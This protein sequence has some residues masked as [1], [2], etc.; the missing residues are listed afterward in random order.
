MT[1]GTIADAV[2][3]SSTTVSNAYNR[4]D[5]LSP[6]LRERILRTAEEFGYPGPNATA[7]TL[8]SGRAGA[9]GVLLTDDL[10]YAFE[11]PAARA[12][13]SGLSRACARTSTALTLV[14]AGSE[15][16]VEVVRRALVDGFALFALPAGAPLL[17]VVASRG[18]PLVTHGSPLLPSHP[19]V[20]I[21]DR[22][23][24]AAAASH[25]LELG[26]RRLAVLTFEL[27]PGPREGEASVR[28]QRRASWRIT[29]ER[30]AGY[31][32]AAREHG[33]EW[34]TIPVHERARNDRE[35]G[36]VGGRSLLALARR[37]TAVLATSDE[38]ALGVLDAAAELGLRVPD[39]VS[40]VGFDDTVAAEASSPALT[41]VHQDLREQGEHVGLLLEQRATGGQS[42]LHQW[43]LVVRESTAPPRD[44]SG[45]RRAVRG[46][47]R[48]YRK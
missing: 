23:A 32:D 5:K 41:T 48:G 28:R 25:L 42:H 43:R 36:L 24:A 9:I 46:A 35:S 21:D 39:D 4:P 22:A 29:R 31:G 13:L 27:G 11:D 16:D 30:L 26:H 33:I 19:F 7:R 34:S 14:T 3:V 20:G 12:F 38:L 18:L 8:R 40:V 44:V 1:L 6:A 47:Q 45:R 10:Q 37:P 15:G 2:G 17:E